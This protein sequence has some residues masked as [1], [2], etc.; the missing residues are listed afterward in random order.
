MN[1]EP[2]G[3]NVDRPRFP[4]Y[5]ILAVRI[6]SYTNWPAAMTQTPRDLAL[7][8]FFYVGNVDY[9]RCFCCGGGLSNWEASD[10]PW[11]SDRIKFFVR[12]KN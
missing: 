8:G 4:S 5:A 11:V 10:D 12:E 1:R 7:A 2:S 3:I 9:T 6:S